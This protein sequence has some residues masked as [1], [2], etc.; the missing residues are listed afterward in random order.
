MRN[1]VRRL[2]GRIAISLLAI[3]LALIGC[4]LLLIEPRIDPTAFRIAGGSFTARY[5]Q[6]G[7]GMRIDIM[8]AASG[9]VLYTLSGS[10][11]LLC[12][13]PSL[14]LA[15]ADGDGQ[16]DLFFR[17]CSG[18]GLLRYRAAT[19]D[20]SFQRLEEGDPAVL[21]PNGSLAFTLGLHGSECPITIAVCAAFVAALLGIARLFMR[22]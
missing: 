6:G 14:L 7:G 9:R 8:D 5:V 16:A 12:D 17:E 1:T 18:Q 21:L 15:D 19:H 22:R 20:F 13:A 4:V 11:D 2:L 3:A 10:T